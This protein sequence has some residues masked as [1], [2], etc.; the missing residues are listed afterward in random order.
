MD[1]ILVIGS[2]VVG[3]TVTGS[4]HPRSGETVLGDKFDMG[5][6]GKG[7]N[8][9]VAI[10]R[11]GGQVELVARV[12]RDIFG[13]RALDLLRAENIG[14]RHITVDDTAHTGAGIVFLNAEGKPACSVAPGANF[15]L[16]EEDLE[17]ARHA[18][19]ECRIVLL[20]MEI[21][22]TTV[23]RG[24]QRAKEAGCTVILD[25]APAEKIDPTYFPRIDILTPNETEAQVLTD[26]PVTDVQTALEAGRLLRSWGV[27]SVIVTLGEQGAVL[28]TGAKEEFFPAEKV[29]V[30]DTTGA[31]DAFNG[32]L[33]YG[34]A[35]H[36]RLEEA[37]VFA[38]KVAAYSVMSLGVVPGLPTM[39]QVESHFGSS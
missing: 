8:Q 12:G 9:A 30:I 37:I 33:A 28:V 31:G 27:R 19:E 29:D 24:I 20:Q 32:A 23:Y 13:Q 34:L 26:L 39:T 4:K 22:L 2:Y 16:G 38:S 3:L 10:A 18:F 36:K 14:L 35:N 5:H 21:P 1:R 17:E 6:G 25:P 15:R 11:L 7:S